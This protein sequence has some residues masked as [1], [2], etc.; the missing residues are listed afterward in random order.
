MPRRNASPQVTITEPEVAEHWDHNADSWTQR[1]RAGM[2]VYREFYNNPAFLAFIGSL[3]GR[4]VLDAGCGEGSNTRIL[5]RSGARLTGV[6]LSA[7]MIELARIEEQREPLGIR[8]EVESFTALSAFADAT[9]DA[10]VSFMALMDGPDFPAA[11][12]ELNRVLRPGGQLCFSILHPCF[13][14]KGFAWLPGEDGQEV[15][16]RIGGYFDAT[17]WVERW[18]F[19]A[20]PDAAAAEPFAVPRFDRTLSDYVNGL[21]DAGFVLQRVHEPRPTAEACAA[22]PWLRKWHDHATTFLYFRALKP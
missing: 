11:A 5:A 9:F 3:R 17:P 2:D 19:G 14:T 15:G 18:K 13:M 7:R 21:I 10:V 8:Y 4:T 1:V 6:D 12:A 20:A 22:H 16:L